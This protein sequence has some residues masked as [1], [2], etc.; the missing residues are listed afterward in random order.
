MAYQTADAKKQFDRWSVSYD[1]DP[2]QLLF[3]RPAH[4][5]LL[6]ALEASDRLILDIGCGTCAFA[7]RV[8]EHL[9]RTRVCGIDLSAGMLRHCHRRCQAVPDRLH[10][11]QADSER[12]PFKD[13]TFDVITCTHS[14]HHYPHQ[15]R[16][17]AEMHRVL[18]PD[19]KL[20]IID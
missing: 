10:L 1:L 11:V 7:A 9:P 18:R 13:D 15:N 14:F 4:Q 6:E 16:A 12:L 20:L 5:M 19:G 8:L 17:I 3:F 2:L